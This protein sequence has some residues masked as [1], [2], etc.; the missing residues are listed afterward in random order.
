MTAISS[1]TLQPE[2]DGV[3]SVSLQSLIRLGGKAQ[4]LTSPRSI[5]RASLQ[6]LHL[7]PFK[8]RGMDFAETRPYEDGTRAACAAVRRSA[9][10]DVLCHARRLQVCHRRTGGSTAGME[11]VEG[12]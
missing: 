3:V 2:L 12:W 1:K 4:H 6:G 11:R 7:S 8:G 10:A 9:A 5:I